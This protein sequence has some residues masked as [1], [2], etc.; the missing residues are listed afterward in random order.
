MRLYV[1]AP[2]G[3][4]IPGYGSQKA[5]KFFD[6]PD[7]VAQELLERGGFST[8]APDANI[9]AQEI[10]IEA[11]VPPIDDLSPK[12]GKRKYLDTEEG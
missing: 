4:R 5:G 3:R 10:W 8:E 6:V 9:P 11:I 7:D 2:E 1:T 12:Q